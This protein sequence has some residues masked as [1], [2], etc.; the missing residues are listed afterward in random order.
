[1]TG[2]KLVYLF[3]TSGTVA[4]NVKMDYFLTSTFHIM[5]TTTQKEEEVNIA[6]VSVTVVETVEHVVLFCQ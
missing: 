3:S 1:M 4:R 5:E 6:I 2:N